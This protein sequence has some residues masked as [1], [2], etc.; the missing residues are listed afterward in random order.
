[1]IKLPEKATDPAEDESHG[2]SQNETIDAEHGKEDKAS[3]EQESNVDAEK[4]TPASD[5]EGGEPLDEV[6][7]AA[8]KVSEAR[9][10]ELKATT[11]RRSGE[12]LKLERVQRKDLDE[13]KDLLSHRIEMQTSEDYRKDM[14]KVTQ[15]YNVGRK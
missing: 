4:S 10:K 3:K 8:L 11:G 5:D 9:I 6:A 12:I 13:M 2:L 7:A 15:K 1:M 14:G